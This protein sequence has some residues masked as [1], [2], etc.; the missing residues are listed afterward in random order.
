MADPAL[1][2]PIVELRLETRRRRQIANEH[3]RTKATPGMQ[4]EVAKI[5]R[6]YIGAIHRPVGPS[7]GY[8]CHGLTFGTR[9]TWIAQATEIAK[10]LEDDEY[11]MVPF[12]DVLPGDVVIYYAEDGD[13]EHSG[14]VVETGDLGPRILS[15]WGKAHEIVHYLGHSPFDASMVK[16]YRMS[17]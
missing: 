8:N 5:K 10:I 15:K 9:R 14:I 16:Y 3:N 13:V 11:Q 7:V 2:L 1:I 12:K 4:L 17:K 6:E